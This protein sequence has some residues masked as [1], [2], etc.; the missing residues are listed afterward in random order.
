MWPNSDGYYS[1]SGYKGSDGMWYYSKTEIEPCPNCSGQG[2]TTSF[3]PEKKDGMK[4]ELTRNREVTATE[5]RDLGLLDTM[6]R[7]RIEVSF[8]EIDREWLNENCTG[9]YCVWDDRNLVGF[10][11][12][13]DYALYKLK[14]HAA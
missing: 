6:A 8:T 10:E 13:E 7:K 1:G 3:L 9:L 4:A 2:Q 5:A 14:F 12:D 11:F